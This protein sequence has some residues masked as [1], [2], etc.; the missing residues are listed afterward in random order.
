MITKSRLAR[1]KRIRAIITGTSKRPRLSVYRS[2][3]YIYGQIIDDVKGNTLA[4][5][6]GSAV[7]EVANK[8]SEQAKK[9]K[10]KEMVFDRGGYKYHGKVKI[11]AEKV[12]EGGV[13]I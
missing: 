5:A 4:S 13:K 3:K 1:K 8:L 9:L 10:I 11:L 6:S 7:T 12:R 2:N